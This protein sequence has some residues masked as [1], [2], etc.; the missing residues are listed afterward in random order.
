[1]NL[2]LNL[3]DGFKKDYALE[4]AKLDTEMAR[5]DLYELKQAL[6]TELKNILLDYDVALK[7][8]KVAKGS[9]SQAEEN[10]R[11]TDVSFKE[12]VETAA[13]VLDAIS[14]LSRAKYNFINARN[15]LF[16]DYY[17]LIRMTGDF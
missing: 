10:L 6:S 11:I 5:H 9:I 15:E 8:L 13:D 17:G 4:K 16:R 3:F 2:S 1:V 14:Y 12:G 7:N